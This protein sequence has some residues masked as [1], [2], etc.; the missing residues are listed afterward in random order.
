MKKWK[1]LFAVT[2]IATM[3]FAMAACG[4]KETVT[5]PTEAPNPTEATADPT[6][7]TSEPTEAPAEPTE[8]PAEPTEAPA[9]PTEAPA[10]PTE[11]PADPTE[12]PAEPTETPADPTEAPAE[13][14]EPSEPTEAPAEPTDTP[15]ADAAT[16]H[17]ADLTAGGYGYEAT[18]ADGA[19]NVT[20]AGQYQEI[21]YVLPEAVDLAQYS[22]LVID[23]TSNSQ[24]DIKLVNP[25]AAVNEYNQ[26]TPFKDNYTAEG[27][28]IEAPV[29]IDLAEFAAYD[30]SQ[31]NFMAMANDTAFTLKNI[32]FVKSASTE[33]PA[34]PT[35]AP[36][37]P[38]EA[39][40]EPT[41]APAEPTEAP[42]EVADTEF[43]VNA[44]EIAASGHWGCVIDGSKITYDGQ[45][46]EAKLMFPTAV[47]VADFSTLTVAIDSATD[48][49]AI[50]LYDAADAQAHVIYDQT[51][52]AVIDLT[53][54]DQSLTITAIGIMANNGACE[55]TVS[56]ISLN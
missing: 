56:G 46:A 10:E 6:E 15:A 3:V 54:L 31:I 55:A 17:F 43:S 22:K 23:I 16:I 8:A 20:I 48:A 53:A 7:P 49:I 4:D 35:E 36:A 21:Q 24:L 13:P 50:K 1:K 47:S 51:S 34:E 12:A 40:A 44:M 39:P 42:A 11:T 19:V 25:D 41:E 14:S 30:L 37:E 5:D 33:T 52:D 18:V 28:A 2:A 38:T 45:Y 29:E 32:S 26:L 9:E 27:A